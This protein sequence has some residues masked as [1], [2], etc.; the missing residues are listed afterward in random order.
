M[1]PPRKRRRLSQSLQ[2]LSEMSLFEPTPTLTHS[3]SDFAY[4]PDLSGTRT[5]PQHIAE[6]HLHIQQR[7]VALKADE[8]AVLQRRYSAYPVTSVDSKGNT[9]VTTVTAGLNA[10]AATSTGPTASPSSSSSTTSKDGTVK[11]GTTTSTK[12]TQNSSDRSK[13]TSGGS[14]SV[15]AMSTN[16]TSSGMFILYR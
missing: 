11:D 2:S 5:V 16:S 13:V 10:G 8:F 15:A 3:F 9:V 4:T 12:K 7:S 6:V 1:A 14:V